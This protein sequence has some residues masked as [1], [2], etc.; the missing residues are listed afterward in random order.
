MGFNEVTAAGMTF[1]ENTGVLGEAFTYQ[2]TQLVGCF[3]QVEI[4]YQFDELSTRKITGLTC[5][6]SKPQ[7][8]TAGLVP[9]NRQL[10]TYGGIDYPIQQI[11]GA[12]SAGEPAYTLTLF[13]LT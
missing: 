6:T 3:N 1:A 2:G 9:A 5:V 12:N 7:W 8:T 11:A 13:R 10:V 4:E